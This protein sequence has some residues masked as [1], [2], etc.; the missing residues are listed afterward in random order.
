M[1]L[2]HPGLA[3]CALAMLIALVG[4]ATATA[5][6]PDPAPAGAG[7]AP[8]PY[9]TATPVRHVAQAAPVRRT[10]VVVQRPV[11]TP[12][13]PPAAPTV[14]HVVS[15]PKPKLRLRPVRKAHP[16]PSWGAVWATS[17]RLWTAATDVRGASVAHSSD[18]RRRLLAALALSLLGLTS[19]TLVAGAAHA[20]RGTEA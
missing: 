11:S 18:S 6:A 2:R 13:A 12:S 15:K 4:V 19:L 3:A 9:P 20:R 8:D 14:R 1:L 5:A 17:E 10:A 7:P 16:L